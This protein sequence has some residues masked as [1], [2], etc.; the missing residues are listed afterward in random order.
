[1]GALSWPEEALRA[2]IIAQVSLALNRIWTEWYPSRGYSFNI[3]GSPGYD[4][5]Y[6][7]GRTVFAVME[8]LT[9][10]LFNTFVQRSGDAEPY[11]TEYC[12]G[13]TVTCP[14]MKQWGTVDRAREGMNALQILR[15]YY[16]NRVQ[17]VTTDNIAAIPSSYP[18]SPLRR[19]STG[20]NVRILQ[21]QLS[22]IAKDYPSFGKPAVTGTFDEATENSVKKFQKQFSLTADGVVGRA[23]WNKVSLIYVS[24]KDLAELTSEGETAEGAQSTGGW[25]GT[26]LRRGSTGSS[27]EQVQFWLSDLAQFDSSLMR[28][29]VDG[30]Y[31]AATERAVR[32]F[33]QKQSL[34]ADGAVGQ[35][36]WNTL[37]AAWVDAQSDLGGTAQG[38]TNK[39]GE[40]TVPAADSAYTD[41]T[42]TAVVGQ[43]TVIVTDTAE[44]PVKGAL[45]TLL[46]GED[47]EKDAFTVLLPDGRLLDGNDQ[48]VV[49]VLLPTAKPATGL[50]VEVSDEQRNHAARDTDKKG[51][52]TVPDASGSAGEIIGT[53]T[54]DEDK[55]NTV[56]VDVAD[57]DGKPVEDAEI[58]VDKDGAV[59][60]T[61]PDD[62]TFDEDGPVTVTITDNQG[63][64]KPGVSV[65][66]EDGDGTTAAGETGKEGKVTLPAAY[67]FAYLVGYRDGTIGPN[68]NMTRG[69]AAAVFARVLSE[70]R[71]DELEGLRRSRFPDVRRDAWYAD[72]VAYLEKLGVVVGYPD[73][74]FHAEATITREQFV[75]MSVR[76][77]EWMELETYDSKRGSFPDVPGS[78][79]AADYIQEAT[80]NGWIVGYADG[81]FHGGDQITRAEVAAIVNRMLGRTADERFIRHNEDE[82][83]TFRDLQNPHYWAYYDLMEAANGHTIVTGAEDE[84]W[85]EVR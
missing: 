3:T 47:G 17:L 46:A 15:Y 56:N 76:L 36:T 11:F 26:V 33:Q 58:T 8:R 2:N 85:H 16:G 34:T 74:L 20:T 23:T 5:A 78:H 53:D 50:N 66:V 82:L 29:T 31:G 25:P 48:T 60:V 42:G 44:K 9:A 45:V 4:Q 57:Q 71:G 55:S 54:G 12:D 14:G 59:S 30:S 27:V 63:E 61:L 43:Y 69:E 41:D 75:A 19:G 80:R 62:F 64:A 83:T 77:D 79:W 6:V 72:Y 39:D 37:Y 24:V 67:H 68:R 51:Q 18:G 65:T 35:R 28:V 13:K 73:G 84:T 7:N 10:E 22:R 40:L 81:L 21:K 1:M 32:A 52:I 49:T 70:A 38:Q